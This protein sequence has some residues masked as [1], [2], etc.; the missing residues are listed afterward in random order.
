MTFPADHEPR[1]RQPMFNLP[2]VMVALIAVLAGIHAI[3]SYVLSD[4]QW[5]WV[6]VNFA[7]IPAR[8]DGF[9]GVLVP[10]E[11]LG[12]AAIWS[13]VTYALLHA[14]LTHLL[15]NGLWMAVFGSPLAWRLGPRRF[16]LFSAAGAVAG[17]V[18]HLALHSGE[19]VPLVGASAAISAH[20]AGAARFLF[21][22]QGTGFRSYRASAAPLSAVLSDRR[23]LAF[24]GIWFALNLAI[25]LAGIGTA[26]G[27][28]I[29]W[30]AH[31]G[32]FLAGLLLFPYFDPLGKARG[33]PP[34]ETP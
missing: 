29:A 18:V 19:A 1:F 20:M 9:A 3:R 6:L 14:D 16:L 7:F 2:R 15:I 13:F 4:S 24:L 28:T 31:I 21:L 33:Y 34:R 27:Q 23:T 10:V 25:G 5:L 17:A 8:F 12:G 32:G 11:V 30:E 22:G 26:A